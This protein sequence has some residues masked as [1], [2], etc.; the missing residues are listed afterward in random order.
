[1]QYRTIPATGVQLSEVCYGSMR[2]MPVD[3][4][5]EDR[6]A[7]YR[8]FDAALERGVNV[9][10]S[11]YQYV[12]RPAFSEMLST[13]PK[14]SEIHHIAKIMTPEYEE[15][16]FDPK[17]FRRQVEDALEALHTDHIAVIQHLQRGPNTPK[18]HTYSEPG[19]AG[20]IAALHESM[21]D[22]LE[23]TQQLKDEGKIGMVASF[24]HTVGYAKAA[25]E[26]DAFQGMVHFFNPLE[27]EM[28]ELFDEFER[29]GMTF[30]AIRP[31]LQGM[32]TD[33]RANR[34]RL[35]EDDE[36][37][38]ANWDA[39]YALLDRVREVIGGEPASWTELAVK[40]SLAPKVMT[41]IVIGMNTEEQVNATLD[42]ADGNYP[43]EA[44][45][46]EV[47]R[48]SAEFGRIPKETIFG[49]APT[50]SRSRSA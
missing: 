10:H 45:V 25:L 42:A 49:S 1:M 31:I 44:L 23:V 14:R 37:R 15:P 33:K 38:Q 27:T 36:K 39:W 19:D 17:E 3:A 11:S 29:R 2:F 12:T 22:L 24:P 40:F 46:R 8:S 5:D 20:R 26:T 4:T 7:A 34:D 18:E 16:A 13:H 32:L 48:V 50:K 30:M 41:S 6:R 28:V 43:D 47:D 9:A 35:P 21:D